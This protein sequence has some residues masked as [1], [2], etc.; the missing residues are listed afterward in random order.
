LRAGFP[1]SCSEG[2]SPS[3][4][5][6]VFL[7]PALRAG[8]PKLAFGEVFAKTSLRAGFPKSCFLARLF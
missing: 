7:N 1:K 5:L 3:S 8:F 4:S 2:F 6:V